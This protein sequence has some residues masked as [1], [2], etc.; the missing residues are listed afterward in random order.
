MSWR[1]HLQSL[2]DRTWIDRDVPLQGGQV[3]QAVNGPGAISGYL[4]LNYP[5]LSA[6]KEWGALL[7]AEQDGANPVAAIIDTATSEPST[8]RLKVEAGGFSMYPTGMPWTDA[9]YAGIQVDPC[10]LFRMV[11]ASLQAKPNGDLGVVVDPDT[12]TVRLGI[13]ED[14]KLTAAKAGLAAAVTAEASAK[15]AYNASAAAK[16]AT[17]VNLLAAAGLGGTGLVIW[18]D[19]APSGSRRSTKNLWIDKNDANKAYVWTGK[20][21]ALQ[22]VSTQATINTLL[23]NYNNATTA[24]AQTAWTAKKAELAAA[25]KKK[26]DIN[27]GDAQPFTLTW[28]ENHDLGSVLADLAKNT[29]FDYRESS[30]WNGE[31]ITHRLELGVPALGVRRPD[32]RFEVGVNATVAPPLLERDYASEVMVL[33]SGTGRAMVRATATG[34]PGRLRRAVVVQRKDIG[35]TDKAATAARAEVDARSAAWVF[36]TLDV[37]DHPNAPYGSYRPGDV[38]YVTGDTGWRVLDDWVR[39]TE[40]IS[41]CVTGAINLKVEAT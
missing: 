9:D 6:I 39:V 8:G 17:R 34:N 25:K 35:K 11:W 15:S 40:I 33:G 41:D 20:K 36:N 16:N 29:P 37:S 26:S 13:P 1:F 31:D 22:T 14:P 21:W 2:P 5:N 38:V 3:I 30:A 27:G 32:L 7:V 23:A 28:W 10:D 12:S 19:S 18:Q 24:P 4:S